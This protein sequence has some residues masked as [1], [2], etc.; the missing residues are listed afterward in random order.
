MQTCDVACS[1]L[2]MLNIHIYV[3]TCSF[4]PCRIIYVKAQP[5]GLGKGGHKCI[6]QGST[7]KLNYKYLNSSELSE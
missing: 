1:I 3:R 6:K 4:L 5:G 2:R 7:P